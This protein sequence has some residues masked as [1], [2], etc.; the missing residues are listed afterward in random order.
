MTALT[1]LDRPVIRDCGGE[2]LVS[3]GKQKPSLQQED[4]VLAQS[5]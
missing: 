1:R 2:L 3:Y 5:R 4:W